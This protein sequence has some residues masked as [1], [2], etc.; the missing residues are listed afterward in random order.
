M[1]TSN[2]KR[3][4]KDLMRIFNNLFRLQL[5]ISTDR[6]KIIYGKS[7]TYNLRDIFIQKTFSCKCNCYIIV[8]ILYLLFHV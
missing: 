4:D 1:K 7:L 5:Y 6:Y 2:M 3:G 8:L